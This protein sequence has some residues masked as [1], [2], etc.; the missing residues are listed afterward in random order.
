[1]GVEHVEWGPFLD[2]LDW[3]QGEHVSILGPTGS[4]KTVLGR[5]LLAKRRYVLVLANKPRDRELD[6]IARR[7]GG[8]R[9]IKSWPPPA[10]AKLMPKVVLWPKPRSLDTVAIEQGAEFHA[11]LSDV[12]AAGG[13]CVFMD[14]AYYISNDLGLAGALK[15]LWQQGR[16]LGVSMVACSQRPAFVP[17]EMYSE[18]SHLFLFRVRDKNARRRLGEIGNVDPGELAEVLATLPE[19]GFAYVDARSGTITTSRVDR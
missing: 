6:A 12:Y 13:W 16:S 5:A 8:Y 11:A 1:M 18:A 15:I 2:G 7:R 19:H 10:P 4:G 17:Q 3:R 14:E 9:R